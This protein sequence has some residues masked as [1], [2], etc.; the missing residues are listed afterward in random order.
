ML[1]DWIICRRVAAELDAKLARARIRSAGLLPDGRAALETP[2]GTVA[3]DFAGATPDISLE[4]DGVPGIVPGWSRAFAETLSGLQIRSVRARPGD[5]L[6]ALECAASSRFGVASSYRLVIELVPRF[7]NVLVLKDDTVVVAA[8]EFRAG[9]TTRRTISR[10]ETYEPPP[11]PQPSR[12]LAQ[13]VEAAAPLA[14]G[15]SSSA[16]LERLSAA[17]RGVDPSLPRLLAE[18]LVSEASAA[19]AGAAGDAEALAAALLQS[20]RHLLAMLDEPGKL[21]EPVF[22]YADES[23]RLIQAHLFPLRQFSATLRELRPPEMLPLLSAS[24]GS[25]RSSGAGQAL[26]ARRAA[27][28]ARIEKRRAALETER[29][30]LVRQRDADGERATLRA[31]GDLLYAHLDDV[32]AGAESFVP[33]SAPEVTIRLDPSLDAKE[34]AQA[35]FRR[36]RKAAT[37][38][39]HAATRLAEIERSLE[40]IDALAWETERADGETFAEIAEEFA[41]LERPGARKTAREKPRRALEFA[42]ENGARIFVGRSPRNNAELTFRIARPGDLWF[43]ARATPGAHVILHLD[44]ER[45]PLASELAAAAQLAA[46]HSKARTSEKVSVDYTARKYVR[47]R[48]GG[49][50]GLVW[51]NNAKTIVVAPKDGLDS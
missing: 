45:E 47:R 25:A 2:R 29:R 40:A 4:A 13:L 39:G 14:A 15:D 28:A 32:P 35:I 21:S 41:R 8:R 20:G 48:P 3:I 17:L 12:T 16:S 51:Y 24:L 46:Y 11:L 30:A 26:Q 49:A 23:E 42:L 22:A 7:G 50:P 18:S 10:G 5:R 36:Y 44:T 43:H 37:R 33:A 9:G 6:I 19:A 31:S 1:T 34:N 27:L 38:S